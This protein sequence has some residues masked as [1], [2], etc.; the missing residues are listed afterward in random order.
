MDPAK[1]EDVVLLERVAPHIARVTL[2]RPQAR[3][4][5][6]GEVVRRIT[7]IVEETEAD[8]DVWV[9]IVTGAGRHAFSA[10]ADLK[11]IA[12]GDI[13]SV[14]TPEAGFA[15]FVFAKRA[16]PWI[17]AVNGPAL[18]GGLEIMLACEL[19]IAVDDAVFGM[20]E[21]RRSLVAGA[22]G[23]WRLPRSLPRLVANRM[24][25]T[26]KPITAAQALH[27]GLVNEVVPFESL[28]HRALELAQEVGAGAP[29]AV[30]EALA[31]ARA[32]CLHSEAELRAQAVAAMQRIRK[33]SDFLEGPRAFVEKR[34]PR[35]QGR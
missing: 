24:I 7:A 29:L 9:T 20:P 4:A 27:F 25:L 6:N 17:A 3:N 19:A 30:R 12:G 28:Q 26:G 34:E 14:R 21:V 5:V 2:N 22:G 11:A 31:V 8:P 16:K 15:G 18:A 33:T 10:G 23:L 32:A 35:W 13:E 1:D